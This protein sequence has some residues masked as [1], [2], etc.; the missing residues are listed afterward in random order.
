MENTNFCKKMTIYQP[1]PRGRPARTKAEE[2]CL[3]GCISCGGL[4]KRV[5]VLWS[6]PTPAVTQNVTNTHFVHCCPHWPYFNRTGNRPNDIETIFHP[7]IELCRWKLGNFLFRIN[8]RLQ[9]ALDF[10]SERWGGNQL[11]FLT[12]IYVS[13]IFFVGFPKIFRCFP[14]FS[15]NHKEL[16]IFPSFFFCN[17]S[18]QLALPINLQHLAL[19]K[20][21]CYWRGRNGHW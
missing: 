4:W 12:C 14:L 20:R 18:C 15:S 17:L 8:N 3:S 19:Q 1:F 9:G 5:G 13:F 7:G 6:P 11:N 10:S 16:V 2:K 21:W